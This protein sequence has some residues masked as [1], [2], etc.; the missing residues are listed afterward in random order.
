M[1]AYSGA[2]TLSLR[3]TF[4]EINIYLRTYIIEN[5]QKPALYGMVIVEHLQIHFLTP[6]STLA[7]KDMR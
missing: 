5:V 1:D 3:N 2:V 7:K 6:M 4:S